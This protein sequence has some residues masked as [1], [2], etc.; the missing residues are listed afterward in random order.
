M[1]ATVGRAKPRRGSRKRVK[2]EP[3][4]LL[5]TGIC[6]DC[7]MPLTADQPGGRNPRHIHDGVPYGWCT[8]A[9][10]PHLP[11]HGVFLNFP[12]EAELWARI[13]ASGKDPAS[14]E[15]WEYH[16]AAD[17]NKSYRTWKW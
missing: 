5:V 14:R 8:A 10:R 6:M 9:I 17:G 16:P 15:N 12:F 3:E 7:R 2:P 11:N 1:G 4:I 13:E